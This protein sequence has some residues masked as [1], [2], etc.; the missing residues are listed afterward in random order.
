VSSVNNRQ[1][2]CSSDAERAGLRSSRRLGDR[3][4]LLVVALVVLLVWGRTLSFPLLWDDRNLIVENPYLRLSSLP[5]LAFRE[6][7]WQ[8]TN[9]PKASGMYR[10]LVLL[11]YWLEFGIWRLNPL[12]YHLSGLLLHLTNALLTFALAR[13]IG[14]T[15][16]A[17]LLTALLFA[18]HPVQL[19]AVA[20]V[21]SRPDLL[22]TALVL[23]AS[24]GW[25]SHG[26]QR[27]LAPAWLALGMWCKESALVGPLLLLCVARM[28]TPAG[29]VETLRAGSGGQVPGWWPPLAWPLALVPR[30]AVLGVTRFG[31]EG[32]SSE[33]GYRLLRY[34]LRLLLPW[35]QAPYTEFEPPSAWLSLGAGLVVVAGLV[36]VRR[37]PSAWGWAVGWAVIALLPVS[38]LVVIGARFSDLL[39]Y[40]PL[41]GVALAVGAA[42]DGISSS[43]RR[44]ATSGGLLLLS[45]CAILVNLRLGSWSDELSLWRYG[46]GIE[47]RHPMMNLNLA[48]ALRRA[49]QPDAAC[50]QLEHTL[51]LPMRPRDADVKVKTLY[52]LGN[53]SLERGQP[54]QALMHYRQALQLSGGTT[55]QALHNSVLALM[56]LGRLEEAQAAATE[57]AR[58]EPGL[59][60]SW[61]L[62][63]VV[64]AQLQRYPAAIEAFGRSLAIQADPSTA[65]ML[66]QAEALAVSPRR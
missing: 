16:W 31:A 55:H 20:N 30:L 64:S 4:A 62:L 26:W 61:R 57:L 43:W 44:V 39:L 19:E 32:W 45:A 38:E 53:C 50:R 9:S 5:G 42:Y 66:K 21:A 12:G 29:G 35:A 6:D 59:A 13:R 17:A 54:E 7:F 24:V 60:R 33:G 63:G 65:Q 36:A 46:L 2:A 15:T 1:A 18:V 27:W 56:Q 11:S 8:L 58:A 23:V 41:V 37:A 10:P 25:L 22:A 34:G 14:L 40:L 51:S 48:T 3:A 47:P 28:R 52:N 49:Q